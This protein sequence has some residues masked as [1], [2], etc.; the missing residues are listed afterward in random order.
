[1]SYQNFALLGNALVLLTIQW[2]NKGKKDEFY[3]NS[4]LQFPEQGWE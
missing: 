1:V 2:W 3:F 4:S